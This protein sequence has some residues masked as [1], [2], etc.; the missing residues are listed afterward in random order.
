[1]DDEVHQ[2]V[3]NI[4][5]SLNTTSCFVTFSTASYTIWRL[6]TQNCYTRTFNM[7][8]FLNYK[9]QISNLHWSLFFRKLLL[10]Y[11]N[12][13]IFTATD[14]NQYIVYKLSPTIQFSFLNLTS[15]NHAP[16]F[17]LRMHSTLIRALHPEYQPNIPNHPWVAADITRR[18]STTGT[19]C[20]QPILVLRHVSE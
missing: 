6:S 15:C 3:E 4:P 9:Q 11:T 14:R 20:S 16:C 7:Y 10:H 5:Q 12:N 19:V 17:K 2:N 18:G 13:N 8:N 1:M